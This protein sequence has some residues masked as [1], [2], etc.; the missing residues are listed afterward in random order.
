MFAISDDEHNEDQCKIPVLIIFNGSRVLF[1]SAI[2][3]NPMQNLLFKWKYLYHRAVTLSRVQEVMRIS[4]STLRQ[5]ESF[6]LALTSR[7]VGLSE[8]IVLIL[9]HGASNREVQEDFQH[10]RLTVSLCFQEVWVAMLILHIKYICMCISLNFPI[11]SPIPFYQI[12]T[13][14]HTLMTVWVLW[15]QRILQCMYVRTGF[16]TQALSKS[17]RLSITKFTCSMWLWYTD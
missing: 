6:C 8:K 1:Y 10:S 16:R 2:R 7:G 11:Q 12:E 14:V 5:L 3:E 17:E 9:G 15:T 13:T 4:L